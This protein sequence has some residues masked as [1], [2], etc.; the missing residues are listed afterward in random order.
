MLCG[1][2]KVRFDV[3]TVALTRVK[4]YRMLHSVDW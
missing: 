3:L 4:C 1:N 2:M